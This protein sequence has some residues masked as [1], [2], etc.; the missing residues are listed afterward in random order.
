VK[1]KTIDDY[2]ATVKG[3]RRE[4]LEQLRA[5]IHK[6]IPKAEECI[7]YGIPAF[8]LDGEIVAGFMARTNGCSY[9][10]FS[11]TTLGTLAP[12]LKSYKRT[13]SSLH[14]SEPLPAALVR[15]LIAGRRAE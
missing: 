11:G 3:P 7:S 2:L 9:L 4:L 5:T 15:K 1:P 12:L 6:I 10:P 8:R 13:K 14:F